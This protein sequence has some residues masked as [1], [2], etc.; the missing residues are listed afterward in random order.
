[1]PSRDPSAFDP[2]HSAAPSSRPPAGPSSAGGPR[3]GWF[4]PVAV[5]I[6]LALA[7]CGGSGSPPSEF[8]DGS[9]SETADGDETNAL[10]TTGPSAVDSTE[11]TTATDTDATTEPQPCM[12]DG[13]CPGD[14]P[15]CMDGECVLCT[16]DDTSLCD[17][18]APLCDE[19]VNECVECLQH[20][21]CGEAACNLFTGACLDANILHVGGPM[22]DVASIQEALGMTGGEPSTII[23]H[24][25]IYEE[26]VEV[27]GGQ[28]VGILAFDGAS[29]EWTKSTENLPQLL[30]PDGGTVVAEGV[31]VVSRLLLSSFPAVHVYEG[32]AW[33]DRMNL[34]SSGGALVASGSSEVVLRNCFLGGSIGATVI[35]V[36][37]SSVD[38]IYS[39]IGASIGTSTGIECD[40]AAAVVLRNSIVVSLDDSPEIVCAGITASNSATESMLAGTSNVAVGDLDTTWFLG[41]LGA[42]N[43][44]WFSLASA[45]DLLFANVAVW[46]SGDP[47]TDI[48]GDPRPTADG[49]MDHAGAD[50]P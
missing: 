33:F 45:G 9:A 21:D 38:I 20:A 2:S 46:E 50:I 29:P 24:D 18:D 48:E 40:G 10:G 7:G 35:D 30:I 39:T 12:D 3:G 41:G 13:D 49:D 25:G 11:T 32:R 5:A 43:S 1:M 15:L 8:E 23:L 37:D 34:N 44:G 47:P 4:G 16:A 6:G 28:A 17:I 19:D 22:A 31:Q 42:Y 27:G 14:T 36:Y 26:S